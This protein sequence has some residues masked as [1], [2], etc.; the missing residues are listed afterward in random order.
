MKVCDRRLTDDI[1]NLF[2]GGAGIPIDALVKSLTNFLDIFTHLC[3]LDPLAANGEVMTVMRKIN[4]LL[5]VAASATRDWQLQ[6]I[7]TQ[8]KE[9]T[10]NAEKEASE[11]KEKEQE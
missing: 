6:N 1:A 3:S 9:E 10:A 5:P 11:H 7:A 2:G 4:G 8:Y